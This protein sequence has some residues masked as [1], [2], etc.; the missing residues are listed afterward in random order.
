MIYQS[1]WDNMTEAERIHASWCNCGGSCRLE[2]G[3]CDELDCGNN[4]QSYWQDGYVDTTD[5]DLERAIEERNSYYAEMQT[6]IDE[7]YGA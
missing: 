1:D 2:D 4:P 6:A 7:R 5:E 3:D